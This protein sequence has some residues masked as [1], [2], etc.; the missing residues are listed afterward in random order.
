M[1]DA[2]HEPVSLA[3]QDPDWPRRYAAE[4]ALIDRALAALDP[5]VEPIGSTAV[6]LRAKPII[7]IQV[8]VGEPDVPSAVDAL[9]GLGYEHHGE[10]AVPGREYLTKRSS[11]AF[12]VHVF[13]AG[14][15]LLDDNRLIRDYLRA[16]P[17]AARE[18]ER[19]K[20]RAVEQGHV[21]LLSYSDAKR[22]QVAAVRD[23]ARVACI[24]E[25][26][27]L[28]SEG[29]LS[30]GPVA[31]GRL[32]SI[33]RL[34]TE[35]GSWAVKQVGDDGVAELLEGA[36]FQEAALAAGIPTPAER[37]TMAG[38]VIGDCG[39]VRVRLHAW[40]DLHHPDPNLDP[41]AVGQLV[42]GLHR[43]D[44]AGSIG[45]GPWYTEPV[46]AARWTE[47]VETLRARRA[48]FADELDALLPEL[49]ALEAHLGSPPRE[50]RTCH[51]DLWADNVRRTR[52]G[53]LCVFDFDNAGLADPSQE[54][55]AVLVE[56]GAEPG[57]AGAI[58]AA[59]EDAGGPGRVERPTDF[60][61]VIAQLS[62]ILV[63]GCRRWLA[64]TTDA[65]RADNESWV[66]EFVDQ[67][68]TRE[69]IAALLA[70]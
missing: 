15:P 25:A 39:G 49:V 63:E 32:G 59:Y 9:R 53:G 21:D 60:A 12:N 67:P 26:F 22:A 13:A 42:A 55:A 23:A 10:G 2:F 6:P 35:R 31:S 69:R 33:W 30:D 47:L 57:R 45:V 46:G 38:E 37:R 18:Y 8:A 19:I 40:V 41:V 54:L 48:P 3:D 17:T 16:N 64:A 58:R 5:V 4:A 27:D 70:D 62:H 20:Q 11:P 61:M 65:E 51:R 66:R 28:G 68:L 43:V 1:A 52:D 50:L 14:N 56:Y 24:L 34:D 44:F 36:A 7:D 29:R